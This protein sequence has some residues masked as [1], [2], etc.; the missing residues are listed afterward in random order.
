MADEWKADPESDRSEEAAV[1]VAAAKGRA[2]G[3]TDAWRQLSAVLWA[4]FL[5]ATASLLVVLLLPAEGW[6]PLNTA[7][8]AAAA[9]ALLWLLALIPALIASVLAAPAPVQKRH[10]R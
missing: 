10:E 6:L 5:G 8:R 2:L 1:I 3:S 9:F 7:A 4:S